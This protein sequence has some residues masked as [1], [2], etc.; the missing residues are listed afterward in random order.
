MGITRLCLL[1]EHQ[2]TSGFIRFVTYSMKKYSPQECEI[3]RRKPRQTQTFS[4]LFSLS[5]IFSLTLSLVGNTALAKGRARGG[6][7]GGVV[8]STPNPQT[9][10]EHNNRA[11]ELG[12]KGMWPDA[13]R[14][15]EEAL[16]MDP[17]N[18]T[19]RMNLSSARLHYGD[20]LANRKKYYEAIK[21][22]REALYVDPNNDPA[23]RN[24]DSCLKAIGKDPDNIKIR[25]SMADDAEVG[26]NYPEA[27]VEYRKC[28]RMADTGPNRYR[29]GKVLVKQG[30]EIPGY[31]EFKTAV[32]KDWQ[33]QEK[34]EQAD[35]HL[36]M[37]DILKVAAQKAKE[38]GRG[39]VF[40]AR[41]QNAAVCYRRSVSINQNSDAIRGLI[42]VAR[43]GVSIN[44][45]CDNYLMLGG[46]YQLAGDF[47]RAKK[48]YEEAWRVA[49][50][51]PRILKARR[52]FHLAVVSSALASPEIVQ[53]TLQKVQESL[54]QKMD[55]AELWY[56]WGR[57]KERLG[58]NASAL[59]GY[60]RAAQINDLIHPDLRNAIA[61]MTGQPVT[62]PSGTTPAGTTPA[63]GTPPVGG[64]QPPVP[65]PKVKNLALYA[66]VET[67]MRSG[68]VEGALKDLTEALDKDP[69]DSHLYYLV[70]VVYEKKGDMDQAA[71]NY[72]QAKTMGDPE[73][74]SALRR[75]D[76][77]RIEPFVKEFEKSKAEANWVAAK[78]AA[79]EAAAIAPNH[80]KPHRML[81][82]ALKQLSDNKESDRETKKADE[83]EK[84]DK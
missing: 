33:K 52:S 18:Q 77:S 24:L 26:G 9:P 66:Q 46:A 4:H 5:V 25:M 28:V 47:E 23:D 14:E 36:R 12:S 37:A 17:E 13:I 84:S 82:E 57:G 2:P 73:A 71:V 31:Q 38:Q 10:L 8:L 35:C 22:Y 3:E 48:Q 64:A 80:P 1:V 40:L 29:L 67:K 63:G 20:V 30:K 60:Q 55:D 27:I 45:N 32:A 21:Q 42:E 19:F 16:N 69:A 50:T 34:N 75:V 81:A 6:G 72:R 39:K 79:T 76:S 58:D 62:P 11:V 53:G 78:S 65:P 54:K 7:G 41:L 49:P 43:E 68:D 61:R 83:L 74:G 15:H 51:D 59:Q 44:P 56:V 70:A